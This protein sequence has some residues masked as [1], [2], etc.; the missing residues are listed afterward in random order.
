MFPF[1][2]ILAYNINIIMN[3]NYNNNIFIIA[4]RA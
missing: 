1:N 2:I 3:K 4:S